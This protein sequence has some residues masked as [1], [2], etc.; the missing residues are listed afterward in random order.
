MPALTAHRRYLFPAT[1]GAGRAAGSVL[2]AFLATL[3]CP[4]GTVDVLL[5]TDVTVVALMLCPLFGPVV[6]ASCFASPGK[7]LERQVA[8]KAVLGP[9]ALR[10]FGWA[11]T[12]T[13]GMMAGP[14]V[15][16]WLR[17]FPLDLLGCLGRN[18]FFAMGLT[19]LG[20]LLLP[21]AASWSLLLAIVLVTW[22]FG[23]VDAGGSP[24][25]WA[26]LLQPWEAWIWAATS[27]LVFL[28]GFTLYVLFDGCE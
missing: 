3:L 25:G 9:V 7:E 24:A 18:A 16:G 6:A 8:H 1:R 22:I 2:L 20:A 12:M 19:M 15:A 28:V 11:L 26:L 10:R 21:P 17:G 4:T 27:G 14:L 13:A 5:R 23:S